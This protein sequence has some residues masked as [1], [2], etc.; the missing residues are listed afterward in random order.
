MY[1]VGWN[2]RTIRRCRA[3]RWCCPR[4][5]H[6]RSARRAPG[7]PACPEALACPADP[8]GSTSEA[9]TAT[10][11][12]LDATVPRSAQPLERGQAGQ[13]LD[14][15]AAAELDSYVPLGPAAHRLRIDG[16][17]HPWAELRVP[18]RLADP[19]V[20]GRRLPRLPRRCA[21]PPVGADRRA[22]GVEP[23]EGCI[24]CRIELPCERTSELHVRLGNAHPLHR[25]TLR[26]GPRKREEP[27]GDPALLLG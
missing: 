27:A 13:E 10:V 12:P 2:P 4:A 17:D 9:A 5:R 15:A 24:R 16:D 7:A 23:G 26:D 18:H 3:R 21:R 14:Q 20:R 8:S 22:E 6:A 1:R 25:I 19:V 11:L